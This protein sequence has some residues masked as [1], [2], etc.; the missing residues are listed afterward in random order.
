M[1]KQTTIA[2]SKITRKLEERRKDK[3]VKLKT[4]KG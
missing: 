2:Q 4:R 3:Q 1:Q